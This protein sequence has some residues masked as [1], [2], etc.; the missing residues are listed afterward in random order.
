MVADLALA[1]HSVSSLTLSNASLLA[2]VLESH[3]PSAIICHAFILPHLLELIYES[4]E[5]QIG[6]TII[7]V[8]DPSPQAMASVASNI[9]IFNFADLE[10]EGNKVEKILSTLPSGWNL[11]SFEVMH[12]HVF[13]IRTQ[14]RLHNL[15]L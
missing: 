10:R 9:K 5:R 12:A 6:H 8:G 14:R 2:P 13:F 15:V 4:S 1:S 7:L 11:T 3:T